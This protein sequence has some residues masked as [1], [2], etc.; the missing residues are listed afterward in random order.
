MDRFPADA[1]RARVLKAFGSLGFIIVREHEHIYMARE[2]ADGTRTPLT[3][4]NHRLIKRSTLRMIL[5]QTRIPRDEFL[6]A[7]EEA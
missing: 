5:T 4:P 3:L 7:Y 6:R 1:P 2:N